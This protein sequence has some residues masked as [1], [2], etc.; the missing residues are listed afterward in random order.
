MLWITPDVFHAKSDLLKGVAFACLH[1]KGNLVINAGVMVA[2]IISW[3][4]GGFFNVST[5]F[6]DRFGTGGAGCS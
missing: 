6:T 3:K 2:G 1:A 4:A 5:W